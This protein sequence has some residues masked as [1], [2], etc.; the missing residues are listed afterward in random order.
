MGWEDWA[1]RI[2]CYYAFAT[3]IDDQIGRILRHLE[4]TGMDKNT[5]V[6]FSADHGETLGSHGGLTDKG[7]HHFEE[8]H[9]IPLIIRFPDKRYASLTVDSF[10]SL[11]DMY[12]TILELA[13]AGIPENDLHGASLLPLIDGKTEGWREHVVTEFHGVNSIPITQRTL[14]WK[15]YKYGFNGF[16][17]DELY[18]LALD[19]WET[20][21]RINVPGYGEI[22]REMR[23]RL[24]EWMKD[25][26]DP[27]AWIFGANKVPYYDD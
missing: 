5:V 11:A 18:D 3:L 16:G 27:A 20:M 22:A 12:P 2:R 15:Q 6:I 7:Y 25:T 23:R 8:T 10:A 26:R 17:A 19:P 1:R 21:N 24:L 13:N 14:R 9:R 4:Q